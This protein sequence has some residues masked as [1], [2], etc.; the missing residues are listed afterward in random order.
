MAGDRDPLRRDELDAHARRHVQA[1]GA[2][3]QDA[4]TWSG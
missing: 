2:D 1:S 3:T 4:E